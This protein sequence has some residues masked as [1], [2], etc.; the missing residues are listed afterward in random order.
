MLRLRNYLVCQYVAIGSTTWRKSNIKEVRESQH[1]AV[2][3]ECSF[4]LVRLDA[5]ELSL[6]QLKCALP[7]SAK[8]QKKVSKHRRGE[9]EWEIATHLLNGNL[10]LN[11]I[12]LCF[13][14]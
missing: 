1:L 6:Q 14:V 2:C 8:H 12:F 3:V 5:Y 9:D 10:M 11:K 13:T 7:L 4:N